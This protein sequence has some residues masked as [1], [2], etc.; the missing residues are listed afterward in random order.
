MNTRRTEEYYS[1][2][3]V[4]GRTVAASSVIAEEA[5]TISNENK[6]MSLEKLRDILLTRM[7]DKYP[8]VESSHLDTYVSLH[9]QAIS[10]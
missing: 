10:T 8:G 3:K 2:T 5:A 1:E 4:N 7:A 6:G 9:V